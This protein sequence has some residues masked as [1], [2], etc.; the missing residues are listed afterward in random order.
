M[1]DGSFAFQTTANKVL[2]EGWWV[3]DVIRWFIC[4]YSGVKQKK[5]KELCKN[6]DCLRAGSFLTIVPSSN[7][8]M[9][10]WRSAL[11]Y[12]K[13][14]ETDNEF[15]VL[16]HLTLNLNKGSRAI[17]VFSISRIARFSMTPNVNGWWLHEPPLKTQLVD[18]LLS[19]KICNSMMD[20]L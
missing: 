13:V 1:F 15:L 3:S 10:S 12:K 11:Y 17:T 9:I 14:L 6:S 4:V 7:N 16:V 8:V 19:Q 20:H 18:E 2:L 5:V